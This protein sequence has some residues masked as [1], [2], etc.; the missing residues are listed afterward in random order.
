VQKAPVQ[1][2]PVQ[3]APVQ[4]A[5]VQN[6]MAKRI[7]RRTMLRA[8]GVAL[9]L[10]WL[11]SQTRRSARG[12]QALR[13]PQ[14][15]VVICS[16]LGFHAPLLF[17]SATGR[18]YALTPYLNHLAGHRDRF[19]LLGGLSHPDQSGADGHSSEVSWL[20]S[21]RHP[22]LPGFRNSISLDQYA[23]ERLGPVT[24]YASLQLGNGWTSQSYTGGGVMLP[25]EP[26]P[27]QVFAR[28]FLEGEPN[29]VKAQQQRLRTGR[30]VLD[31]V[32]DQAKR[33]A[34]QASASDRRQ[35][36]EYFAAVREMEQQ[37]SAAERWMQ[38]PKPQVSASPPADIS[39]ESDLIGRMK[40]LF[41]LI[42]LALQT[43]S[44]RVITVLLQGRND[45]PP[46]PGV[47]IDHHNLSH[48]GQDPEKLRQL[49]LVE[50][51]I[52][53]GFGELLATLND[54]E[55]DGQALLDN[56]QVLFGSNL[57]NANAHDPRNLP[58]VLAGGDWPH[59][60][61]VTQPADKNC[62]LSNLFVGM[63]QRMGIETDRFGSS[64][65]SLSI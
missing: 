49:Q 19:T 55:E 54:T 36:E 13:P 60:G 11:E 7:D 65:G 27:S 42:P 44:T 47:T 12:D 26:R 39:N 8:A 63:L 15:M 59:A 57:G 5:P 53:A 14:R 32:G 28:L 18:D 56:T 20:T 38:R 33:L 9:A 58:I 31:T 29:E 62:P 25:A 21:A 50:D 4:K 24:R 30:S 41:Q 64:D 1:K 34:A 52:F 10:P 22:G 40:L 45:V 61:Y 3:K 51:A 48:H 43:D 35:L 6:A 23:V 2:A 37:L 17:P 46:V 16:S